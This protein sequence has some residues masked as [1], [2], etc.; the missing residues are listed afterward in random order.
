MIWIYPEEIMQTLS[1]KPRHSARMLWNASG[2]DS[3]GE[4]YAANGDREL[5]IKNYELSIELNPENKGGIE[6]LK[7]L[8]ENK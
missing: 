7:K 3:L 1:Q 4:A 2:Y 5:A 6:A 8:R